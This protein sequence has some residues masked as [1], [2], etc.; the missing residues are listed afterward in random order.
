MTFFRTLVAKAKKTHIIRFVV[1]G[2]LNTGFS[3]LIYAA[4][5]HVGLGYQTA[6]LMAL[7]IG[8][9]FSFKTQG[10]LVFDNPHDRLL[11][12]FVLSWAVI[13]MCTITVIGQ[14]I[15]VGFDPYSAG[16]LSLP[17]SVVLSYLTQRYF[18]FRRLEGKK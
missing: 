16:A 7:V 11:G 6:N 18:V 4:L 9:L 2:L 17:V 3:Y 15:A 5:L 14:L 13:Y 1:V 8:V 10:R 12:R